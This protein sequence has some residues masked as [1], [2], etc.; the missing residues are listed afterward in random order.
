VAKE[1]DITATLIFF[2]NNSRLDWHLCYSNIKV[3]KNENGKFPCSDCGHE[4]NAKGDLK[5]HIQSVHVTER[6]F[7]CDHCEYRSK[8]APGLTVH[9]QRIHEKTHNH[10]C[11]ECGKK[12]FNQSGLNTHLKV[13]LSH[14]FKCFKIRGR[15]HHLSMSMLAP[16]MLASK[17]YPTSTKTGGFCNLSYWEVD[18]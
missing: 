14:R 5:C 6:K 3:E 12:Y 4:F 17:H 18:I 7:R 8:T 13:L 15:K 10:L 16:P 1:S 11:S 9:V 2:D